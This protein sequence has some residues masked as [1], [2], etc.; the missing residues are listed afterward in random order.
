MLFVESLVLIILEFTNRLV[1]VD[2]I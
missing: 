2:V 1:K